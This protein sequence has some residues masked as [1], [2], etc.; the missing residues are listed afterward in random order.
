MAMDQLLENP[1][2]DWTDCPLVFRNQPAQAERRP[3]LERNSDAGGFHRR[4][5][6]K[7]SPR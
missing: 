5:S 4:E 6:Q 7:R 1:V 2:M 3:G